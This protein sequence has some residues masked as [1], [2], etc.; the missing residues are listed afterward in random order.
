[1]GLPILNFEGQAMST[2]DRL[3][4]DDIDPANILSQVRRALPRVLILT[5]LAFAATFGALTQV[6]PRF[7]SE[8]ELTI[9]AKAG[10]NPFSDPKQAQPSADFTSSRMDKEAINTHI[11]SLKSPALAAKVIADLKLK[12]RP[13]FN[14]A[15]GDLDMAS[16]VLR[17]AGLAGPRPGQ[18]VEDR[19]YEAFAPKLEVYAARES[20]FI[21]IRFTSA[22]PELAA[23]VPNAL[24]EAYRQ[25]LA[26][27]QVEET[28]NVQDAL[29]PK[30]EQMTKDVAA[31]E[32]AVEQFRGKID[33]FNSGT[34]ERQTLNE[35]QLGELTNELSKAQ[36]ARSESEARA[37]QAKEMMKSGSGEALPDVQK[38][39][40]IQN[41]V[42]QRVRAERQ[43]S[44]LSASLLPGHPRMRQLNADLA[45]LKS[46]INAEVAKFVDGLLKEAKVAAD[47]EASIK[48]RLADIKVTVVNGGPGEAKLK[49]LIAEAAS[50][51]DELERLRTQYNVNTTRS[52]S[53]AVPIEAK[54]IATA[55]PSSVAVYPK[56]LP[57]SALVA[58]ATFLLGLALSVLSAAATGARS[59]GSPRNAGYSSGKSSAKAAFAMPA[60]TPVL[61][62]TLTPHD[63]GEPDSA[64][65]VPDLAA[66]D[67]APVQTLASAA[68][69]VTSLLARTPER[70][71]YRSLV[72][73]ETQSANATTIAV[74][75][76]KGLAAARQPTLLVEWSPGSSALAAEF[77]LAS[78]PGL[79][80]LIAGEA[81]FEDVITSV[82]GSSCH[83][84]PS[85]DGLDR[86]DAAR[87]PDQVNLILDALDEAYS[88]IVVTGE[89]DA[90]RTL[91]ETIEGRFDAGV[92][93]ADPDAP[94]LT[95]RDPDGTFLGFEVADIQLMRIAEPRAAKGTVALRIK[96]ASAGRRA[97]PPG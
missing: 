19:V 46:Q 83:F 32:A 20:R 88:H 71:A 65:H 25:E 43:I 92:I 77:G 50:K 45:G 22:D 93:V 13:E 55:T 18:T 81:T 34:R 73:P 6:A 62:K 86:V 89:H 2:S 52:D 66:P 48:K 72:A 4:P 15:L 78:S 84:L 95:L 69:L 21:G 39:P 53:K 82:P 40:L 44:E 23:A 33:S 64:R 28:Q 47:R 91:F 61:T 57:W 94:A 11:Q 10:V 75:L 68:A 8:A 41:L 36:A 26:G 38:S 63:A 30:I 24:A 85:G 3:S 54:L 5:I 7:Q 87:D 80:E 17:L 49:Q 70:G 96:D 97:P 90:V 1:M 37:N 16:K 74:K 27:R 12:D 58:L 35:Q 79:A 9:D 14:S 29:K 59:G 76:A 31:A 67:L 42:Q 60:T 56:K 51:R